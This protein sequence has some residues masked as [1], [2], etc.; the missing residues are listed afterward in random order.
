MT[1]GSENVTS[2]QLAPNSFRRSPARV[3]VRRRDRLPA[4]AAIRAGPVP[5]DLDGGAEGDL[6]GLLERRSSADP[7][8]HGTRRRPDERCDRGPLQREVRR[9]DSGTRHP[10][11]IAIGRPTGDAAEPN[12]PPASRP[13]ARSMAIARPAD[14]IDHLRPASPMQGPRPDPAPANGGPPNLN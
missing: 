8:H 4:I 12:R 2:I 7:A 9:A 6:A 1:V 11:A 14:G 5:R 13:G 10:P 3:S